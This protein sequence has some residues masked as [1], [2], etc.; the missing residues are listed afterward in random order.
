MFLIYPILCPP[1]APTFSNSIAA[2]KTNSLAV[3]GNSWIGLEFLQ[4]LIPR[5]LWLFPLTGSS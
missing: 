1:P 5:E 2:L 3:T 4:S